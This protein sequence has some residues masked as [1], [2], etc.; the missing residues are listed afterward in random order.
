MQKHLAKH[1]KL[2]VLFL[3]NNFLI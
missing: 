3:C 1:R 2:Y